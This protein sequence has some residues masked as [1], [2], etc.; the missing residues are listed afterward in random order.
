MT[1]VVNFDRLA[2]SDPPTQEEIQRFQQNVFEVLEQLMP[3]TRPQVSSVLLD[4]T[5]LPNETGPKEAPLVLNNVTKLVPHQLRRAYQGYRVCAAL[6]GGAVQLDLTTAHDP[7][8]HIPLTA[9]TTAAA[10]YYLIEVF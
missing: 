4:A 1:K 8:T 5:A 3:R 7:T 9:G 6:Q 10:R 2:F